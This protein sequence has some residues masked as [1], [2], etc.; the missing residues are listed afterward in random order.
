MTFCKLQKLHDAG[1]NS[2]WHWGLTDWQ[3]L[4]WAPINH[5]H[6]CECESAGVVPS[7]SLTA[8][9]GCVRGN[10]V[11]QEEIHSGTGGWGCHMKS[12]EG[13]HQVCC[14]K[15]VY[16]ALVLVNH[17]H[18]GSDVNHNSGTFI[19]QGSFC[20]W[21]ELCVKPETCQ[22]SWNNPH[23]TLWWQAFLS[24]AENA[25]IILHSHRDLRACI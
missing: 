4:D 21:V 20:D 3:S 23:H 9:F 10:W 5:I 14:K 15:C 13:S 24:C 17:K 12:T 16:E 18:F 2:C 19:D 8:W 6:T 7:I 1:T 25:L 11:Q 22:W